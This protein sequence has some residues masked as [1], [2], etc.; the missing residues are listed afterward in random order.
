MP[1]SSR[2]AYGGDRSRCGSQ[3][4]EAIVMVREHLVKNQVS[5][6]HQGMT[7]K[8]AETTALSDETA[9][10]CRLGAEERRCLDRKG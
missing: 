4:G 1:P 3:I 5:R 6:H 8:M 9:E 10:R 7:E 2:L